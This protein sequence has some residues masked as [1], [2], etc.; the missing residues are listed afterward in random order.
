[1]A[2]HLLTVERAIAVLGVFT[3]ERR[4]W[5]VSDL[6]RAL[7]LDKSQVHR[8]VAT[9]ASRG[10]LVA[11]PVSR[12]YNLGPRIVT[13]GRVAE[14]SSF[15]RAVLSGLAKTCH[16]SALFCQADGAFY[17][18]MAAVNGPGVLAATIT[19]VQIP[20][21]GGGASGDVIF[22]NL[23]LSQAREML[24]EVLVRSDGTPGESWEELATRYENIRRD[25][26]AVSFGEYD[27][28]VAAVAA[29]VIVEGTVVGSVSVLAPRDELN[30]EAIGPIASAVKAAAAKLAHLYAEGT[31]EAADAPAVAL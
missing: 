10:F 8:I 1:M 18:C 21:Y 14:Q 29:P 17:R 9:L 13:L 31:L 28:R 7:D 6:A 25:G 3:I 19:G 11:D 26:V 4:Q 5:G 20:G 15:A 23:P 30:E 12:R 27:R 16:A 22:A 2:G 24:G